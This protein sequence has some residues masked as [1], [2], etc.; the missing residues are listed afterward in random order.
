MD[1]KGLT[2]TYTVGYDPEKEVVKADPANK[3]KQLDQ[4]VSLTRTITGSVQDSSAIP[5]PKESWTVTWKRDK[6]LNYHFD[7][8]KR[9][10][11]PKYSNWVIA[12]ASWLP[13]AT[14][15]ELSKLTD[16]PVFQVKN[17]LLGYKPVLSTDTDPNANQIFEIQ[18]AIPAP[19]NVADI[20]KVEA[21]IPEKD[22]T[23]AI[24][25]INQSNDSINQDIDPGL[26]GNWGWIDSMGISNGKL[27]IAGWNANSGSYNRNYHY[28]IIVDYGPNP[29]NPD[30]RKAKFHE[31]GRQLVDRQ[32]L[33]PDV[34][35]I[36][37]V[38]N[39]GRSG[40]DVNI[41]LH[42]VQPGD[43]LAMISRWTSDSNGNKDYTDLF[44][45]Y[46]TMD[47]KT[48][49]GWLDDAP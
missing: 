4:W 17:N 46:F 16:F 40:F 26:H 7:N 28:I 27:H 49:A 13:K 12:S 31:V 19:L 21:S 48:N 37:N 10:A 38:Y 41:D 30:S 18:T 47:Y 29:S 22:Y 5:F 8:G 9:V 25:Y 34:K 45:N 20:K 36:H 3:A 43:K 42:D 44:G 15:E 24:T 14:A 11:T 33:R 32:I 23:Y 2:L 39:A 6:A 1:Q 35:K